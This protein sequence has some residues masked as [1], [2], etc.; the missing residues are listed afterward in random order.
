MN[1]E[2]RQHPRYDILAQIRV[3]RGK[4]NYIMDVRNL[5][6]SGMF[7]ASNNIKKLPWFKLGQEL[8]MDLFATEELENVKVS[9]TIV[10]IVNEGESDDL[11]FGVAFS[12]LELSELEGLDRLVSWAKETDITPPPLPKS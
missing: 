4:V 6:L 2:R 7:V 11:G 5:S 1:A 8:E 3:K 10:R 12:T 9:G